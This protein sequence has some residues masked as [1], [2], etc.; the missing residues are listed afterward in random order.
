MTTSGR[1]SIQ[2]AMPVSTSFCSRMSGFRI[3]C[4]W[5][6][7]ACMSGSTLLCPLP[8]PRFSSSLRTVT[9]GSAKSSASSRSPQPSGL[10]LSTTN[11]RKSGAGVWASTLRTAAQTSS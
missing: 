6:P 2:A 7:M 8:N 9:R 1:A 5:L 10:A 11:S 3:K 4:T